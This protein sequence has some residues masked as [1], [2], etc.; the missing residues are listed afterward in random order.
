MISLGVNWVVLLRF[1]NPLPIKCLFHSGKNILQKSSTI[2][3][4]PTKVSSITAL[5]YY[6]GFGLRPINQIIKEPLFQHV[7]LALS[8]TDVS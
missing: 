1:F 7:T 8:I 2:Q 5:P 6:S 4:K 3:N